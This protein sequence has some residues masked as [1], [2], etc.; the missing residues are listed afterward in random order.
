MPNPRAV[1]MRECGQSP[2]PLLP[3]WP[4][5]SNSRPAKRKTLPWNHNEPCTVRPMKRRA[6]PEHQDL[7][8]VNNLPPARSQA[9]FSRTE[10]HAVPAKKRP[11]HPAKIIAQVEE[12]KDGAGEIPVSDDESEQKRWRV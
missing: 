8:I 1:V 3:Q 12:W 4:L 7:P 9:R 10:D 2:S 11:A 6:G 5:D